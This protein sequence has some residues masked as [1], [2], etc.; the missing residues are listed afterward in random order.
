MAAFVPVKCRK[1]KKKPPTEIK[2]D[3][4]IKRLTEIKYDLS[5]TQFYKNLNDSLRSHFEE[6]GTNLDIVCYGLGSFVESYIAKY[7]LALL[8]ALRENLQVR[9]EQCEVYDPI[10]TADEKGVL[11]ELGFTVLSKNEEGKRQCNPDRTTLFYLPHCGKALYNN[12]LWANWGPQLG[13]VVI[14][15]NS[16]DSM[17]ERTPQ[18]IL[19]H[20]ANY[21]VKIK[22][23]TKESPLA[24]PDQYNDVFNDT[25]VMSFPDDLLQEVDSD[26][27][28]EN[29]EPVYETDDAEIVLD[30]NKTDEMFI[31]EY[32]E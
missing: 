15:G 18:R 11:D 8:H 2:K 9:S 29:A 21:V 20:T 3:S 16:F 23:Y 28:K 10:F 22:Q 12:V 4:V 17:I 24:V 26:I 13:R 1:P 5:S 31:T 27:W 32:L 30:K 14:V 6:C 7:Q 25:S 19:E